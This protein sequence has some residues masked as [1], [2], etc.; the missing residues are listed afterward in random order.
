MH[1]EFSEWEKADII[2]SNCIWICTSDF[3]GEFIVD[4]SCGNKRRTGSFIF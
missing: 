2:S 4:A 3:N 1:Y